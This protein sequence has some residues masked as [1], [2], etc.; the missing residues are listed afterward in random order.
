MTTE[1]ESKDL[2]PYAVQMLKYLSERLAKHLE[3]H[4]EFPEDFEMR[5]LQPVDPDAM[6]SEKIRAQIVD[7]EMY[8]KLR[9]MDDFPPFTHRASLARNSTL[10]KFCMDLAMFMSDHDSSL[11]VASYAQGLLRAFQ[12]GHDF[13]MLYGR[14]DT[15]ME[16]LEQQ[17]A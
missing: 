9:S 7:S 3:E 1:G 15:A 4:N 13:H 17:S 8:E 2:H 5:E 11:D 10:A 6:D 14:F 12:L 16:E